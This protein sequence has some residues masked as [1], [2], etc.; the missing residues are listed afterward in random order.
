MHGEK[1][2][3]ETLNVQSLVGFPVLQVLVQNP[4]ACAPSGLEAQ[5]HPST[6]GKGKDALQ[7][8]QSTVSTQKTKCVECDATE[9]AN[10][11][12]G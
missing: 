8:L 1:R 4:A 3:T 9:E 11:C 12:N 10:R 2:P 5:L 6:T 7:A